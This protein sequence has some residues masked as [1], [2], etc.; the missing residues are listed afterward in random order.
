MRQILQWL[1]LR[2][3]SNGQP[4]AEAMTEEKVDFSLRLY[5]TKIS[6]EESWD[7]ARVRALRPKVQAVT[8]Q[9]GFQKNLID[10]RYHVESLDERAHSGASL[11]A[12]L[13]VLDALEKAYTQDTASSDAD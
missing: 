6:R 13:A 5:W 10:R 7:V 9:P 3:T 12:L 4:Q 11:L 2:D 8:E 1:G